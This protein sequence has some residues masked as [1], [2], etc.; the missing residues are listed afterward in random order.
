MYIKKINLYNKMGIPSYFSHIIKNYPNVL[1]KFQRNFS[2]KDF[3][4]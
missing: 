1:K 2:Q 3:I 4:C